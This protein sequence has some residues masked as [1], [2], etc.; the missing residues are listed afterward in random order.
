[1]TVPIVLAAGASERMGR[2][3]ALLPVGPFRALDLVLDCCRQAGCL[4][5]VVVLGDRTD[6]ILAATPVVPP[7]VLVRNDDWRAGRTSSLQ[8]GVRAAPPGADLLVF[9]VDHPLV[10]PSTVTAL[11]EALAAAPSGILIATPVHASR[12]GHPILCRAGLAGEILAL[13]R[14][15]PLHTLVRRDPGRTL[16]VPVRDDGVVLNLNSPTD[17]ARAEALWERRGKGVEL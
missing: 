13:G 17:H 6:L 12:R 8:A 16:G 4:P 1:M 7:A 2:P 11:R 10:L 3:K 9:P 15:E 5:P 14:D